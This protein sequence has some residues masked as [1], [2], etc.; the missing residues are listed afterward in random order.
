ML[1]R[2]PLFISQVRAS[3][4]LLAFNLHLPLYRDKR[5]RVSTTVYIYYR[6][7]FPGMDFP[8]ISTSSFQSAREIINHVCTH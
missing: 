8:R 5:K 6:S 2:L 4:W 1:L 7:L 3:S